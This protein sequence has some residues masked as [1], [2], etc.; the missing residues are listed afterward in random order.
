MLRLKSVLM[1]VCFGLPIIVYAQAKKQSSEKKTATVTSSSKEKS[2]LWEISGRGLTSPSYLY[3]TMHIVCSEDAT[4]SKGLQTAINK[5]KQVFFEIDM[6]DM[7]QMMGVLSHARMNNGLKISDLI[8]PADYT[9]LEEY[10]A[11]NKSPLP[12]SMMTRFK[13]YFITALIS[14]SMMDCPTKSSIEQVIMSA[15]RGEDKEVLGLETIEFQA[16]IFDKIPYEKQAEDL[17]KYIDSI[18]QYKKN[19]LELVELYK[20]QDVNKMEQ[21]M[22]K[23]DPG[24]EDFMDVLLY[25][26]NKRWIGQ[27]EEQAF[28][29]PTLFAV[30]AG[31]LGGEK[32]VINL[33]RQKGFTVKP[34]DN[35][36]KA[37]Q[38]VKRET[39]KF[40]NR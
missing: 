15:A 29:M 24:M 32:G 34:L 19:T 10:F 33:L 5:S 1:F 30:G 22:M 37:V 7:E 2:L 18:D 31:H 28:Q 20:E 6:D 8:S 3:G 9:R 27:I 40:V 23:Y 12:F 13:P 14:E 36:E 11:K 39:A 4:I 17:V 38:D 35:T 25:D 26:R 21:L 16:S